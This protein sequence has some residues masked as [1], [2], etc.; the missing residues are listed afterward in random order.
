MQHYLEANKDYRTDTLRHGAEF[1]EEE[2]R[3]DT[4]KHYDDCYWDYRT[5]WFDNEN[6]ALHYGY[7]EDGI[8]THSQ[9]LLNKNRIMCQLAGIK[10]ED[11]VSVSYTHLT[12]P[13][14]YSV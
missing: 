10:P 12:L 6:L 5:A 13:T 3:V 8:K 14:I 11:H 2:I 1:T 7:W 9:A 4:A